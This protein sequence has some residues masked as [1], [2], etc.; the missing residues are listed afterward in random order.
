MTAPQES[1]TSPVPFEGSRLI[2]CVLPDAGIDRRL[3]RALREEKQILAAT[4][5]T[6]RGIGVLRG[7]RG[8]TPPKRGQLP[9]SELVRLVEVLVPEAQAFEL[10][11]YI[12]DKAEI[13]REGGGAIWM[14]QRIRATPYRLPVDVPDETNG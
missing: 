14:S 11:D 3:I 5:A 10:F 12:Y 2:S 9:P 4:T 1:R 8:G 7:M 13:G 6:C